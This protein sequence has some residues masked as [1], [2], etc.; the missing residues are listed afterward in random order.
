MNAPLHSTWPASGFEQ[1]MLCPGSHVLQAGLPNP[2]SKYAAEGTAAH[3]LL[4]WALNDNKPASAYIGRIIPVE[5]W[6]FE[7][8]DDMARH[9]QVTIDYVQD[10][11]GPDGV[12]LVDVKVNYSKYLRVPHEDAW[13]TGDVIVIL[14]D[15]II[16]IDL[17]YGMG[18]KVSPD[19]NPQMS[20]YGLGALQAY[21]GIAGDFKRARLVISQPRVAVAP[22]EFDI[23]VEQLEAWGGSV[24]RGA[25]V[26]CLHAAEYAEKYTD[27]DAVKQWQDTYLRPGQKQCRFC[28]AKATCPALRGEVVDTVSPARPA[29]ASDFEVLTDLEPGKPA[30]GSQEQWLSACLSKVD[31]IEDWCKA[32]RAEV[33]RRLV[34]GALVPG[35]KLVPGKKGA[36]AWAD[37]EAAEA[38]LKTMRLKESEMY[39]WT[40]ISPTTAEKL[41][42]AK[43]IGPKQWPKLQGLIRQSDGKPHVAP[44]SDPRPALVVTP[45]ADEFSD[46]TVEEFA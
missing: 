43:T 11:A 10:V 36:R 35:Y 24:A 9:V 28:R 2:S 16:V 33:E 41:A 14:D 13:G 29:D 3:Q 18:V 40:L 6:I 23:S 34:A 4:T 17:K 42:K 30:S 21:Q 44:E 8:D 19:G 25:V 12:V 15:E 38:A 1:K 20:L 37:T 46:V 7:V 39:D 27:A 32:V 22:Q 45:V 5:G 31:L 26:S